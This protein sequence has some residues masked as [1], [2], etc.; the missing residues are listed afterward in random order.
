MLDP[1]HQ[2]DIYRCDRI[3]RVGGGVCAL[4]SKSFRS[5][6]HS[7]SEIQRD[8]MSKSGCEVVCFDLHLDHFKYRFIVLYRP[9]FS[10][11]TQIEIRSNTSNLSNLLIE[12]T[13]AHHTSVLAGDFNLPK[14]CWTDID[15]PSDGVHDVMYNC[16]S[17]LGLTQFVHES[18]RISSHD[19]N[20]VLD[21]VLS[22]DPL[23]INIDS[24]DAPI[25]NSDHSIINFSIYVPS[26]PFTHAS[27]TNTAINLTCYDWSAADY[28]A[29][30][31]TLNSID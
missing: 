16:F 1:Q 18:T 17:S 9:P 2:Y 7:L 14:I 28:D 31:H 11:Q 3:D 8:L 25:S 6:E 24:I 26:T 23:C 20:N 4:I 15:Y 27:D 21:L 19:S 22:N 12:L 5:S 29:I 13:H 10:T 30:N